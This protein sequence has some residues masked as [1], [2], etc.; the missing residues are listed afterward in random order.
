MFFFHLMVEL[1]LPFRNFTC[2]LRFAVIYI[3]WLLDSLN[4]KLKG[5]ARRAIVFGKLAVCCKLRNGEK[6]RVYRCVLLSL[7]SPS[8]VKQSRRKLM[9]GTAG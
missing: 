1:F 3:N 4:T 2:F 6:F 5:S 7:R 8:T 9:Q